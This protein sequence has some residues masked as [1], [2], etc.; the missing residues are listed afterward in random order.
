MS[1]L[2]ECSRPNFSPLDRA[3]GLRLNGPRLNRRG[4]EN[5]HKTNDEIKKI[6][7]GPNA[8]RTH[9]DE[10]GQINIRQA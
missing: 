5:K 2:C 10:L 8:D 9:W 6:E 3:Y 1:C 4:Q 7:Q